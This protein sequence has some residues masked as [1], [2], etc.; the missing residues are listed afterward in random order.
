MK[1]DT[2]QVWKKENE[3][4]KKLNRITELKSHGNGNATI[5]YE[6]GVCENTFVALR[7]RY[8]DIEEA[9]QKGKAKCI[10]T[11]M[12]CLYQKAIGE[13]ITDEVQHIEQTSTGTKKKIDKYIKQMP[14]DF[15]SIKYILLLTGGKEYSDK[16]YEL[17]I[18]EKRLEES[19]D[20]WSNLDNNGNSNKED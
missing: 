14:R 11:M 16:K 9:Y 20:E 17:D 4:N 1:K 19:K 5:A 10:S 15:T 2:Y 6:L 7:K 13:H 3:L 18:K 8:K 12:E